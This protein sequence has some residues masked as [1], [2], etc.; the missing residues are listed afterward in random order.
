MTFWPVPA[1][2]SGDPNEPS[3]IADGTYY[4]APSEFASLEDEGD[5][6]K[7]WVPSWPAPDTTWSSCELWYLE[8]GD[9]NLDLCPNARG[10]RRGMRAL[11]VKG[12]A[13]IMKLPFVLD[14]RLAARIGHPE[15]EN[16][17]VMEIWYGKKYAEDVGSGMS[18][19]LILLIT[20]LLGIMGYLLNRDVRRCVSILRPGLC[21]ALPLPC[22]C[23]AL[24]ALP[25]CR[26]AVAAL[27]IQR[28]D[29]NSPAQVDAMVIQPIESMVSDVTKLA[30]N[31]AYQVL[32]S[33]RNPSLAACLQRACSTREVSVLQASL[34][35]LCCCTC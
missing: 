34:R 19:V 32:C 17:K 14:K 9:P 1:A 26:R 13:E 35:L 11:R 2:S 29:R 24:A 20:A 27:L 12:P 6:M 4:M 23:P 15:L 33:D 22:H 28:W 21:I 3:T 5:V 7:N 16:L 25:L 8:A 31:P 10:P 18:L 30:Q